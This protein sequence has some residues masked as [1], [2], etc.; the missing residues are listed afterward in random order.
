MDALDITTAPQSKIFVET[1]D[2]HCIDA[3]ILLASASA[4]EVRIAKRKNSTRS[5]THLTKQRAYYSPG[6]CD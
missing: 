2:R 3:A 1:Q 4:F 6:I 5:T